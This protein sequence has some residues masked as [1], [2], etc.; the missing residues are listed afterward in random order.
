MF[1]QGKEHLKLGGLLQ[2]KDGKYCPSDAVL[3]FH[4]HLYRPSYW[5]VIA[6]L[7]QTAFRGT[8]LVCAQHEDRFVEA[9]V[10]QT[11]LLVNK[12]YNIVAIVINT[13]E[14]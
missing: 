9:G 14:D 2:W 13:S 12:Q 3:T 1:P 10:T 4:N 5:A 8:N 11:T 6:H 7:D